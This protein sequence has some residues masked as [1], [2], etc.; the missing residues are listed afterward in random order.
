MDSNPVGGANC[1]F[2]I[3]DL[4]QVPGCTVSICGSG[5]CTDAIVGAVGVP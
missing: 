4:R 2:N 5:E 3:A 1:F